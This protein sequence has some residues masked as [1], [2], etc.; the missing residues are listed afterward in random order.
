MVVGAVFIG[1]LGILCMIKPAVIWYIAE[2]W[3][4]NA[5][6]PSELYCVMIRIV[7]GIFFFCA[8]ICLIC[9]LYASS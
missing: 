6:E 5:D 8:I 9:F 4:G 1:L 7:G 2:K 3:K